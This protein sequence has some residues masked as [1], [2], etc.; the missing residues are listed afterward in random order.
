[1]SDYIKL[2]ETES[3]Q[4]TFRS[5]SNYVQ[6]HI[7]YSTQEQKVKF[8]KYSNET[9]AKLSKPLTFD[10]L[11]DGTL[12]WASNNDGQQKTIQYKKNNDNWVSIKCQKSNPPVINVSE[13]D[14]IQIKGNNSSYY[15]KGTAG[16]SDHYCYFSGTCSFNASGNIMSL[17]SA[18][19][20][21][22]T[23]A[24]WYAL[25]RLFYSSNIISAENLV[26]PATTLSTGCYL[27]MFS[28]SKLVTPPELPATT[29]SELCYKDMFYY[30]TSLTSVPELP[31]TT[32]ATNCYYQMFCAC[33]N[34]TTAQS[35]LPAT[36][37]VTGCYQEMF[38][39][40]TNITSAPVL[41]AEILVESCYSSMFSN[42][43]NLNYVE[44]MATDISA[45]NCTSSWLN[46]VSSTGTFK[47]NNNT[48][49]ST[50]SSGIPDGWTVV[51]ITV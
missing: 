18:N 7:S 6:P 36:T 30:C 42:C 51:T 43:S 41:P 32:L 35:I 46:N 8:N 25:G 31:A 38:R 14:V 23:T 40:C 5:G 37:L 39:N 21:S 11:T 16:I 13:G 26:L 22:N 49:W 12:I 50:G 34:L 33:T 45:S 17:I 19:F 28:N 48:T 4:D 47:K 10:I 24:N 15:Y 3:L 27:G 29:L 44:C 9:Y 1:M 20:I 2:F